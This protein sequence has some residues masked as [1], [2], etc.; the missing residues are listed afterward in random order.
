MHCL[1]LWRAV[2]SF[3]SF[4]IFIIMLNDNLSNPH[5]YNLTL[6]DLHHVYFCLSVHAWVG[7]SVASR[8][9][10]LLHAVLHHFLWC[11][12]HLESLMVMDGSCSAHNFTEHHWIQCLSIMSLWVHAL[13]LHQGDNHWAAFLSKSGQ[14]SPFSPDFSLLSNGNFWEMPKRDEFLRSCSNLLSSTVISI[15]TKSNLKMC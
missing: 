1:L 11:D 10:W 15:M 14:C 4:V 13:H 8:K 5:S 12:E 9:C 7:Q 3:I 6:I 2:F